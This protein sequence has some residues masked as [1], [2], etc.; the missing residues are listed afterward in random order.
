MPALIDSR[1]RPGLQRCRAQT[2]QAVAQARTYAQSFTS[3][4]G[5]EVP[6]SYIDLGNFVQ[7]VQRQTNSRDVVQAG[8]RRCWRH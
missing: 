1:E 6:A 7:L 8:D 3:I 2:R 4:F 5:K